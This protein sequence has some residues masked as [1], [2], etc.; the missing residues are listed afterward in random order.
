[1]EF[2]GIKGGLAKL[3]GLTEDKVDAEQLQIGMQIEGEHTDN[4]EVAK[5]I[6]LDHLAEHPKYY[7]FLEQME[8]LMDA[9]IRNLNLVNR[10][11]KT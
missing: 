2:K 8:V 5:R 11:D 7:T 3:R 4:P 1:M 9:H 6:A 10:K